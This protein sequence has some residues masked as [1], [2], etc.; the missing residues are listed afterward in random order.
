MSFRL[1][2][3]ILKVFLVGVLIESQ[4]SPCAVIPMWP[5]DAFPK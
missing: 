1:G 2:K 3:L 5:H 4:E